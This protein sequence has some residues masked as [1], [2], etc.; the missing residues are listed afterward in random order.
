VVLVI[1]L[2]GLRMVVVV[3]SFNAFTL[4]RTRICGILHIAKSG[5]KGNTSLVLTTAKR[6]AAIMKTFLKTLLSAIVSFAVA[7]PKY[8]RAL[9]PKKPQSREGKDEDE[10]TGAPA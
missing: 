6:Y 7:V 8:I 3:L 1:E 10:G 5:K 4:C 2:R 9:F